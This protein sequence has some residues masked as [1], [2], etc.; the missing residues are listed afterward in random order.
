MKEVKKRVPYVQPQARVIKLDV[1]SSLLT[2]S[3]EKSVF[4]IEARESE[5]W[6]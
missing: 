6:D 3:N 5:Y 2:A 4:E 1:E